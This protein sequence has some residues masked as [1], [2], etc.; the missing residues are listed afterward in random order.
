VDIARHARLSRV[1]VDRGCKI[2]PGLIVGKNAEEDARRFTRTENG[3]TLIT[4]EMLD[5]L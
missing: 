3:I 1:I 5:R 2:P 4:Q